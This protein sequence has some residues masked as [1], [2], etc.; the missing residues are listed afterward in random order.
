MDSKNRFKLIPAVYL[1]LRRDNQILLLQRANTNYQNG[2]YSLVAGHVDGDELGTSAIIREAKEEAG[3]DLKQ[4]DLNFI[5]VAHRLNR[6][7]GE[8]RIDLF[9][10]ATKWQGK[11]TNTEPNK[12]SGMSWFQINN[13]PI[14]T[15][16]FIRK[17]ILNIENGSYYSEYEVEPI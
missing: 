9:Y 1:M 10:E 3:I 15:I 8:E 6:G 2:K 13:L 4:K 16:P 17:T 11:I 14:N 12:C 5:H 7:E